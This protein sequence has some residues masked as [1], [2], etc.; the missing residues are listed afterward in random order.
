MGRYLLA[1]V[2]TAVLIAGCGGSAATPTPAP[3]AGATSAPS[4]APSSAATPAL[5]TP[6]ADTAAPGTLMAA[7]CA[8]VALRKEPKKA[9]Q[10]VIRVAEGSKVN[11]VAKVKGDS[12]SAGSCGVAGK[13]WV[14]VDQI[15]GASVQALYGVPFVYGAAG[16]FK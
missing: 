1:A 5:A 4:D 8:A 13:K 10:L 16:F 3:S 12:Y 15:D 6:V 2:F 7:A 11:V 9:A 14:K